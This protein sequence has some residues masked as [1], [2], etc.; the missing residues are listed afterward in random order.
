MIKVGIG[1][2]TFEP[3][4]GTFFPKGL[5]HKQE[6]SF[7][8]REL[9]SIEINGTF[10]RT[11]KPATFISWHDQTPDDFVFAVKAPMYATNRGVLAEAGPAIERFFASGVFE[12]KHK[13]GP[14]LWQFM[15]TKKFDEDDFG[16]FLALLP[17]EGGGRKLRHAVE[18]RHASF[19]VP[20]FVALAKKHGAA[21]VFADSAKYPALADVTADFVYA[22]L[23]RA[24][25][26][27]P[28]GYA[29]A[30]LKTWLATART[31]EAGGAPADLPLVGKPPAKKP[32]DV[33]LYM[34]N[35]AKERAPAAAKALLA[36]LK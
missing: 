14:I 12:L 9:T 3:W 19:A 23:Q 29:P 33:F 17:R 2:W 28:T 8:S 22:R 5:P 21:I 34:I 15:P 25:T 26:K 31:W 27:M 30:A 20:A 32:R 35:G 1:G 16:A 7:A 10:Y 18:V 24:E 6:L 13:L 36:L 11:Q 4:R